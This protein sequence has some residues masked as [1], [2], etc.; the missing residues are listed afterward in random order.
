LNQSL[1]VPGKIIDPSK[2]IVELGT[3]YFCD[4]PVPDAKD[5]I[6]R[7]VQLIN[8]S[9]DTI[10]SVGVNKKKNLEQI[11]LLM[12]YKVQQSQNQA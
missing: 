4:K 10:E 7:K 9:I 11:T 8:K 2:V 6:D 1:Y 12:N 5:L 3:G